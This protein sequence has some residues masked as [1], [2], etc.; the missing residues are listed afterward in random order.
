MWEF[1][2]K[3]VYINLDRRTDRDTRTREVLSTFGNK[4]IRMSAVEA[5]PGFIGCLQSHIAVLNAAKHYGWENVLVMEDD[6]EWSDL[7]AGYPIVQTLASQPYDI[8]HFGP[9]NA[10]IDPNTYRLT[11]GLTTSS[12]LVNGR[13]IDT[14]LA[15]YKAALP[16]L[17][18]T[19]NEDL[20]GSDQCWRTLMKKDKWFAPFPTLMYQRPDYSDIRGRFQDHRRF[21]LVPL[22]VNLMGG[23]GNQLFQLAALLHVANKTQRR[24]YIQTLTN[25]SPHSSISYFTTLFKAFGSLL[26]DDTKPSMQIHEPRLSYADWTQLLPVKV[27]VEMIGYFQ[28]WRYV[29]SNFIPSLCFPPGMPEKYPDVRTSIFLHI[30]GGDYVG[31]AYHDIGLDGYYTRAIALF[32]GAHFFVMTNDVEYAKTRPFLK[33]ISYTLITE[34]ELESL[35]L[36]SL[37]AGGICANSSFSWWGAFLNP[38]RKIVMPDK[39]YADPT[40]ATE[41]YYFPGV[42]KCQV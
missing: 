31:N 15:C 13:Y 42:I 6:V 4:V 37:C 40:L 19:H 35:Y 28:D 16:K 14:L 41:G 21:W 10:E 22:T 17:I 8:I 32:P 39:W 36:L 9:S 5:T 3:V 23:L 2:E 18:S 20:Y 38:N 11:D 12:Y 29:D 33:D 24:S 1:V 34:P 7:D 30:R 27:N 25:P 26:A